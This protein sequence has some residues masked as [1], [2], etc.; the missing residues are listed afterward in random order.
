M[1]GYPLSFLLEAFIQ[2]NKQI[3]MILLFL[4]YPVRRIQYREGPIV[5]HQHLLR[6]DITLLIPIPILPLHCLY[7]REVNT[8]EE[9]LLDIIAKRDISCELI[10]DKI[11]IAVWQMGIGHPRYHPYVSS[12]NKALFKIHLMKSCALHQIRYPTRIL[13]VWKDG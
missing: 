7:P 8:K 12:W 9:P 3:N 2:T 5:R 13:N 10:K 6:Q 4:Q 1:M 11:P